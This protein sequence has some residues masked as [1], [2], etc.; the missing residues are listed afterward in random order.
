VTWK[1]TRYGN[2]IM[3]RASSELVS[4]TE[5]KRPEPALLIRMSGTPVS[6]LTLSAIRVTSSGRARSAAIA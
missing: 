1:A 3:V 5:S 6:R 4:M 2:S